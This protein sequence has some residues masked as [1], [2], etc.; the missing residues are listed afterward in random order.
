MALILFPTVWNKTLIMK[1]IISLGLASLMTTFLITSCSKSENNQGTTPLRIYLTDDPAVYDA[2]YVD[3][4]DIKIKYSSDQSDSGWLALNMGRRGVYNLL[5]FR[6]GFD[7]LLATASVPSGKISQIRMVL[8]PNN[9]VVHNG[10]RYPLTTPSAQ[11]SGLKL[12]IH[13]DLVSDI[14][15]RLWLDFDAG[16]SIVQTGNGKYILKPVIRTYVDALT[17]GIKGS[18]NPLNSTAFIYA[19][20]NVTDTVGAAIPDAATG[21]FVIRGLNAG[22]YS[23]LFDGI[24]N[25][26]DTTKSNVTVSTGAVTNIGIQVLKP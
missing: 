11:Q 10:I 21:L 1:K 9:S 20:R 13:A 17:G 6:N 14:D 19:V 16:R 22:T 24:N 26:R 18:I 5:D 25:F 2:V 15:Y 7:T 8:G 4:A 3:I 23:L 12:N